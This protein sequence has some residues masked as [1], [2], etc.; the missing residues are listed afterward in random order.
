LGIKGGNT[1]AG[2][3]LQFVNSAGTIVTNLVCDT[4]A[5]YLAAVGGGGIAFAVGGS[6][7]GTERMRIDSSGNVGIGTTSPGHKLEVANTSAAGYSAVRLTSSAKTYDIGVGGASTGTAAN[8]WYVFDA[9]AGAFRVFLDTSGTL[10]VGTTTTYQTNSKLNILGTGGVDQAPIGIKNSNNA[11]TWQVGPDNNGNFLVFRANTNS[12]AYLTTTGT[13]WSASSDERLKTDLVP[14]EDGLS[15]V[16][17]LRALTG[18]FKSDDAGT[19]RAFLIAQ[20]VQAVLPEAVD[21][22][23]PDRLGL[24]YSD[25]IPLLVASIKELAAEVAELKAKVA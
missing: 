12:G 10:M 22:S 3:T 14:I 24:A 8:A 17:T 9:T 25:V 2:G 5:T 6:G 23:N 15:K 1:T 21:A 16:S 18:R 13:T 11:T 7:T 4:N 19:S 20:D